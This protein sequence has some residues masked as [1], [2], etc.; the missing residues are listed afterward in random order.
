MPTQI[1]SER[2]EETTVGSLRAAARSPPGTPSLRTT[3]CPMAA[4][5]VHG[6]TIA[7]YIFDGDQKHRVGSGSILH[8]GGIA[9]TVTA[10]DLGGDG[11]GW[12][13]LEAE[14]FADRFPANPQTLD[15]IISSR[16]DRCGGKTGW[17]G[18]VSFET[19]RPVVGTR[20]IRCP[21][22]E[23]LTGVPSRRCSSRRRRSLRPVVVPDGIA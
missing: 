14:V 9:L 18:S 8:V 15:F 4:S 5:A 21:E 1:A 12:V 22:H 7:L 23:P 13:E 17:D 6:P 10:V 20:C 2:I 3:P 16:C 19:G 11:L